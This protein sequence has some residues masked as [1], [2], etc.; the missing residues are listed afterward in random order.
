MEPR[1]VVLIA[2]CTAV[3]AGVVGLFRGYDRGWDE[4]LACLK[5]EV[6]SSVQ[7]KNQ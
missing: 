5:E 4:A 7:S 6:E 3:A 1:V 2:A